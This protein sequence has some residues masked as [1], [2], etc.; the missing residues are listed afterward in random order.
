MHERL[1]KLMRKLIFVLG[2]RC[3]HYISL[4]P[5]TR[6]TKGGRRYLWQDKERAI[7]PTTYVCVCV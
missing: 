3:P 2:A 1:I 4:I 5:W 7:S 6:H